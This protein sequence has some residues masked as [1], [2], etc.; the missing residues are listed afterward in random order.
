MRRAYAQVTDPQEMA[1]IL[2]L[3]N[4]GRLATVDAEGYPYLTPVNFV[5]YLGKIYFHS[6]RKGEKIDNLLRDPRVG[7]EA[8]VP[9]AYVARGFNPEGGSCAMHQLYHSVVVRGTA[10]IVPD[11]PFKVEVLGALVRK[12]EGD[13]VEPGILADAPDTVGCHLVEIEPKTIT[14]KSELYQKKPS[15][16]RVRLAHRLLERNRPGDRESILAMG[17]DP[18]RLPPE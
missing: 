14:G 6:A 16:K 12:H 7:F 9:L 17:F 3:T 18:D 8:D 1:R 15:E 10:R 4:I 13:D 5:F 2:G 11:G